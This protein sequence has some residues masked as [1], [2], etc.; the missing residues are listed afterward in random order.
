MS[1]C[2]QRK[3]S[4]PPTPR[5]SAMRYR[6]DTQRRSRIQDII[7]AAEMAARITAEGR[8]AFYDDWKNMPVAAQM[9]SIIRAAASRLSDTTTASY[10]DIPW[11]DI[12]AC[13]TSSP[14][15]ITT[16][17]QRS[18]GRHSGPASLS[19]C[20]PSAKNLYGGS[21]REVPAWA[22][23]AIH[24]YWERSMPTPAHYSPCTASTLTRPCSR[25]RTRLSRSWTSP[26]QRQGHH[27]VGVHRRR[28]GLRRPE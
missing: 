19:S 15:S 21:R 22:C 13:G 17:S 3:R 10:P 2:R 16:L 20:G 24:R 18:S 23:D 7:E 6:C 28:Y 1:M 9:I 4:S 5:C 25:S 26:L 12:R 14:T 27:R 11:D 8:S